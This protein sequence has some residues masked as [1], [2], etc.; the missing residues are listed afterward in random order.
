MARGWLRLPNRHPL[1][2]TL[3]RGGGGWVPA[4]EGVIVG[5]AAVG[6]RVHVLLFRS[7][8]DASPRCDRVRYFQLSE[9]VLGRIERLRV[10]VGRGLPRSQR[11]AQLALFQRSMPEWMAR[12]LPLRLPRCSH[13]VLG[14]VVRAIDGGLPGPL[15]LD[16]LSRELGL[17]PRSVQRLFKAEMDLSFRRYVQLA[18]LMIAA[19]LLRKA[20]HSVADACEA[21]GYQSLSSFSRHFRRV[22]GVGPS[23]YR[24]VENGAL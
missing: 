23:L 1:Q 18:R 24:G 17:S 6:S 10:R 21:A 12:G 16:A 22:I 11:M 14:E 19:E 5:D 9:G 7:E 13:P 4:G 8:R 20:D 3:L 2:S 15:C